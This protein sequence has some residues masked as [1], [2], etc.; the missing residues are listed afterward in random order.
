MKKILILL[1]CLTHQV[2]L[3]SECK[4]IANNEFNLP[5]EKTVDFEKTNRELWYSVEDNQSTKPDIAIESLNKLLQIN[6]SN[7]NLIKLLDIY[8]MQGNIFYDMQNY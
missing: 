7:N 1:L 4:K 6:K 2:V 3:P 5:W 8:F